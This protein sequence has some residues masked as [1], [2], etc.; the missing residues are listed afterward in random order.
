MS[1][2]EWKAQVVWSSKTT[3]N[4]GTASQRQADFCDLLLR[5]GSSRART[6]Q[7]P[8]RD[9]GGGSSFPAY[10]YTLINWRWEEMIIL[11]C[12]FSILLFC[13]YY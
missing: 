6:P 7:Q 13:K 3:V 2:A 4:E 11:L 1:V 10:L 8:Q 9:L 5:R 12:M